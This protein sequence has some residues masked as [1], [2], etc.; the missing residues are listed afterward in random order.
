MGDVD[1][2]GIDAPG[3]LLV[4]PGDSAGPVGRHHEEGAPVLPAQHGGKAEAVE[5]DAFENPATFAHPHGALAE[6]GPDRALGVQADTVR[7]AFLE[8]RPE[9]ALLEA[10]VRRD[11]IGGQAL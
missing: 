7:P 3:R 9:P 11:V 2:G 1:P 6:R 10:P 8:L 5:L 4:E